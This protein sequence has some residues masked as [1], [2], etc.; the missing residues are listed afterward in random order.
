MPG[1]YCLPDFNLIIS[2]GGKIF[3][4]IKVVV[5]RQVKRENSSLP[6]AVRGQKC[7]VLKLPDGDGVDN[8]DDDKK[9]KMVDGATGD[10]GKLTAL[11]LTT[12]AIKD[13]NKEN[14]D[15]NYILMSTKPR[16]RHDGY[17]YQWQIG[18]GLSSFNT[19]LI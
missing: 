11:V 6:V 18:K 5:T 1:Q 12:T 16:S 14:N 17:R 4:N 7:R 2:N 8:A 19:T 15:N 13:T 9:E 10:G 3:S